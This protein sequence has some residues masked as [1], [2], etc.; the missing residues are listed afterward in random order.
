M[1][2]WTRFTVTWLALR[3]LFPDAQPRFEDCWYCRMTVTI[4]IKAL[5][6]EAHISAAIESAIVAAARVRGEVVLADSGSSDHTLDI[7]RQYHDVR[8]VQLAHVGER[9]CGAG[10]QLAF[11]A[12][13]LDYFYLL[14]GDMILDPDFIERGLE[15]LE[16]HPAYAG[17]GGVV[18]E[19]E[20]TSL[21]FAIRAAEA[22]KG[23]EEWVRDVDRLDCGGLYRVAA[24]RSVGY[25]A[26]RNL[27]AFEEFDLG[28]RL[29]AEGWKLARINT[30]AI[31]HHG[32]TL[33]NAALLIRRIRTGYAGAPGE[34]ARAAI[35]RS[36]FGI[37]LRRFSHLR[38]GLAVMFWWM[39]LALSIFYGE[40][41]VL[42][43]L[44]V[45]PLLFLWWR[46][47]VLTLALQSYLSWNIVAL[48]LIQGMIRPRVAPEKK[49]AMLI[50]QDN[51][52]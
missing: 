46:R 34:I 52:T 9:C 6:E 19:V 25:F 8:I 5:N 22:S 20:T 17:V 28:A 33:G 39:L 7:A 24:I 23:Q 27:H 43:V 31:D 41:L 48:G 35:G 26:D 21:E 47:G 2:P 40:T 51:A 15:F 45:L 13:R 32:H 18:R 42:A 10:A 1:L 49:I 4:G 30:P 3:H 29:A 14:D 37:V 16:A 11:Q 44:I 36:H 12:A 50:L 38:H